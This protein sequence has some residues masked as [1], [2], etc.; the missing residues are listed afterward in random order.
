MKEELNLLTRDRKKF[1]SYLYL[2]LED[3]ILEVERRKN[4]QSL[5]E[6]IKNSV[7]KGPEILQ[8]KSS[9]VLFRNVA[10][11]NYETARFLTIT[12]AIQNFQPV[13]LEY[14]SDKFLSRNW[15]K[16]ALGKLRFQKGIN[17]NGEPI[18]ETQTIIDFTRADNL[19]L[20]DVVTIDGGGLVDFH[21]KLFLERYPD[22]K[23]NICDL[24]DWLKEFG[25]A[26]DYYKKFLTLFLKDAILCENF[27]LDDAEIG[28]TESVV[29]PAFA[30]IEAECGHKPI[31]VALAPTDIE[32]NKF[33][34]SYPYGGEGLG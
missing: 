7:G 22:L 21:H 4:D 26:R 24:S 23:E 15:S 34:F 1:D 32:G 28:F 12:T 30:Q 19:P 18:I 29:M 25:N 13:M 6:Y 17:K 11:P 14:T 16:H 10:T 3:A 2:S 31:I 33:W 20:K 8:N 5:A 27:M 9:I